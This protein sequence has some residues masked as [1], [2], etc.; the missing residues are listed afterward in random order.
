MQRVKEVWTQEAQSKKALS[1]G[2]KLLGAFQEGKKSL[3]LLKNLPPLSLSSSPEME[4]PV[5]P[6]VK[7]ALFEMKLRELRMVVDLKGNVYIVR[8][9][10]VTPPSSTERWDKGPLVEERVRESLDEDMVQ[11]FTQSLRAKFKVR[12]SRHIFGQFF[13]PALGKT[14]GASPS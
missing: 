6:Q 1:E 3:N 5:A 13:D 10:S 14:Q 2:K 12:I 11:A 8:L 7:S 9:L 4:Q